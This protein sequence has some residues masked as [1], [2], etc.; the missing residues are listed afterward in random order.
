MASV[1]VVSFKDLRPVE[2]VREDVEVR[3][4]ALGDEFP[5]TAPAS[6]PAGT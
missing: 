6:P 3:C 4:R 2:S 5:P 1:V